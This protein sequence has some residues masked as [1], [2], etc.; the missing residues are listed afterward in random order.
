MAPQAACP[1]KREPMM[2]FEGF[3]V[4]LRIAEFIENDHQKSGRRLSLVNRG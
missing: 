1:R 3:F 2:N 4:D